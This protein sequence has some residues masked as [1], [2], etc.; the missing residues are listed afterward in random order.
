VAAGLLAASCARAAAELVAV[1]LTVSAGD[2]RVLRAD[3]LAE[4]AARTA[5][6]ARAARE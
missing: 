6:L 4:E 5:E 1:N 2:E 3:F